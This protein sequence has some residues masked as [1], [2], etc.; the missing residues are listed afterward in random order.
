MNYKVCYMKTVKVT[1]HT[2]NMIKEYSLENETVNNALNR[3]MDE[4]QPLTKEDRT[5]TNINLDDNTLER[6]KMYK[7]YDTESHSDTIMRLLEKI[8]H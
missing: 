6:L 1:N 7:A 4:S 3:L 2:R 8:K 5:K